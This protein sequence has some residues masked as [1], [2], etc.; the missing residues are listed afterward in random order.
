MKAVSEMGPNDDLFRAPPRDIIFFPLA[1]T[2]LAPSVA[3]AGRKSRD[4]IRPI[5]LLGL[6]PRSSPTLQ[7]FRCL[8]HINTALQV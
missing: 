5:L 8:H 4:S 3:T 1:H 7:L 2:H 6:C